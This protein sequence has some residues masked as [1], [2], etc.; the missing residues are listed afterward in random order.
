MNSS[1]GRDK[2]S[3]TTGAGERIE[4]YDGPEGLRF[5]K[6]R[7]DLPIADA[8]PYPIRLDLIGAS[9]LIDAASRL[10]CPPRE[11][12]MAHYTWVLGAKDAFSRCL[13]GYRTLT[14]QRGPLERVCGNCSRRER[15][16]CQS[17]AWNGRELVPYRESVDHDEP[18]CSRWTLRSQTSSRKAFL[19]KVKAL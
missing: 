13:S 4:V 12:V 9:D 18:A 2:P 5:I 10:R 1:L 3:L 6:L 15:G 8:G 11:V 7:A 19:R 16:L 14:M 17:R